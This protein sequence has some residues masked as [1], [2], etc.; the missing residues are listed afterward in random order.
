MKAAEDIIKRPLITEQSNAEIANGKY[1][2]VVDKRATKVDIRKAVEKLFSVKVIQVNTM[3][4]DGKKKRLRM[5]SVEGYRPDW[6]KAIVK[7]D[8][9]PKQ[10][11]YLEK[12]GKKIAPNVKYKTSIEEFGG[13]Q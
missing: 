9:D 2:F 7:I 5:G 11:T 10:E 12:G 8:M 3:N 4:Y 1:T 13:A 6:K